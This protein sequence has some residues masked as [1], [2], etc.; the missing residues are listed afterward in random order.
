[1]R[2]TRLVLPWS[3][4]VLFSGAVAG[5]AATAS[6]AADGL[7]AADASLG[8]TT[9]EEWRQLRD[10]AKAQEIADEVGPRVSVSADFDYGESRRVDV[11]FHMYD[12]AYVIVGHLDATGRLKIVFPSAPGD[13]GFVRGDKMYYVPQFFAGFADEYRWR[14]SEQQYRYQNAASKLDSYDAGLAYVFVIASWRPMRLDRISDGNRWQNYDISD[15]SYMHDP[16]EAVEELGSLIAGDNREAYTIEYA[17]YYS[18]NYGNYSLSTFNAINSGACYG[19]GSS[20]GFGFIGMPLFSPYGVFP[21]SSYGS[22]FGCGGYGYGYAYGYPVY[23]APITVYP[24]VPRGPRIPIG[25]PVVHFPRGGTGTTVAFHRPDVRGASQPP[26]GSNVNAAMTS[27]GSSYRRPGL[28][29]EDAPGGTIHG[30]GRVA[31]SEMG[32][33]STRRPSIQQMIG[34][35]QIDQATRG[36]GVREAGMRDVGRDNSWSSTNRG[37]VSVPRGNDN[38]ARMSPSTGR[39]ANA[40]GESHAYSPPARM[41]PTH[42]APSHVEASHS[43]PARSEPAR[44]A[45]AS[46]SSGSSSSSSGS[47]KKP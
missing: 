20:L 44:S 46:S 36:T 21:S 47:S 18:T 40:N 37:G 29:T 12:D 32:L 39:S 9:P 15:I 45:P 26:S 41:Q 3:A 11:R 27:N 7:R 38:G 17:H 22:S 30:Q 14:Y 1:M 5:C 4:V 6:H 13:D 24:I 43:A 34:T 42:S 19:Y 35:R 2:A 31:G 16:R 23:Y 28:I 10:S 33:T 25:T 8:Q